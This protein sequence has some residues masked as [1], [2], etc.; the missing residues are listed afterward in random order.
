M[1]TKADKLSKSQLGK[2]IADISNHIRHNKNMFI[3]TSA[4]KKQGTELIATAI[5][6]AI[7]NIE[8]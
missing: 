8:E 6:K 7:T 4:D 5:E 1:L 3:P 2:N